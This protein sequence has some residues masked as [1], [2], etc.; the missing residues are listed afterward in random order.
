MPLVLFIKKFNK[1]I[2]TF[3]NPHVLS[4][5]MK[6][7]IIFEMHWGKDEN[8]HKLEACKSRDAVEHSSWPISVQCNHIHPM[9]LETMESNQACILQKT[10]SWNLTSSLKWIYT[11]WSH[12]SP[13][14][15]LSQNHP[16]VQQNSLKLV[17]F[18]QERPGTGIARVMG[19]SNILIIYNV[20][21]ESTQKNWKCISL[22]IYTLPSLPGFQEYPTFK[23]T[24]HKEIIPS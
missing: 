9:Y 14:L 23:T 8:Q 12:P 2:S 11:L 5:I 18:S 20:G 7:I 15:L 4:T 10:K 3:W 24:N 13:H 21:L 1:A 17:V 19:Y 16:A 22:K 6:A